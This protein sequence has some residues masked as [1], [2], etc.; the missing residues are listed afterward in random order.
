MGVF[1][2]RVSFSLIKFIVRNSSG[3]AQKMLQHQLLCHSECHPV[4]LDAR[5]N[6]S[7]AR[8]IYICYYVI[9]V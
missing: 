8:L 3:I 9:V 4:L 1:F 7:K 2:A 6:I 5:L